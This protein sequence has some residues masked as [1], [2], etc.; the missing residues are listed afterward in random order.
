MYEYIIKQTNMSALMECKPSGSIPNITT[1]CSIELRGNS[2][3]LLL[4][5]VPAAR[6]Q[7]CAQVYQS[8]MPYLRGRA[9]YFGEPT[10]IFLE[11]LFDDM[12]TLRERFRELGMVIEDGV[13]Y[14]SDLENRNV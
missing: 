1:S 13:I 11:H 3:A 8:K 10:S 12:F 6:V 7:T 4:V 9:C 2:I 5:I 14:L